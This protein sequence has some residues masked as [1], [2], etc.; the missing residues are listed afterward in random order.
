MSITSDSSETI[1]VIMIKYVSHVNYI[2]LDLHSGS[3]ILVMKI[4][5]YFK[6]FSSSARQVYYEDSPN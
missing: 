5:N 3:Q 4:I 6:H 2:D 1:E